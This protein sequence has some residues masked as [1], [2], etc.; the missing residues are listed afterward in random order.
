MKT[1]ISRRP[2]VSRLIAV[3]RQMK[4]GR[5]WLAVTRQSM[6]MKIS[7]L[8]VEGAACRT[9]RGILPLMGM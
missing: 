5:G 2:A 9:M 1:K 8:T 7:R 3:N 6:K 4:T